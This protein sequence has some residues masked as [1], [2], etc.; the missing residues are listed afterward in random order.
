M[1]TTGISDDG[2]HF[3]KNHLT[4]VSNSMDGYPGRPF[5][6]QAKP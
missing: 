6:G 2:S 3:W 5:A 4:S 1:E